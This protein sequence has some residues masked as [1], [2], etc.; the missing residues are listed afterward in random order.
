MPSQRCVFCIV[1]Y[2]RSDFETVKMNLE[3]KRNVFA[4]EMHVFEDKKSAFDA[5]KSRK[6]ASS[7][8]S[9]FEAAHNPLTLELYFITGHGSRVTGHV[10]QKSWWST[11]ESLPVH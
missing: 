5:E 8:V 10:L 11:A 4:I 2:G 7:G 6:S 9:T 1:L 3:N